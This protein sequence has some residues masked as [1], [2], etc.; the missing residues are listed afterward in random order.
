M[1]ALAE[2]ECPGQGSAKFTS[3]NNLCTSSNIVLRTRPRL[4][5]SCPCHIEINV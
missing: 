3:L 1:L 4:C 5:P 2:C